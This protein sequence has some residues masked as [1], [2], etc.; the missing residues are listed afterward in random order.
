MRSR[1]VQ[2]QQQR[3]YRPREI[4]VRAFL[5]FRGAVVGV[6][7]ANEC[8]DFT[9]SNSLCKFRDGINTQFEHVISVINNSVIIGVYCSDAAILNLST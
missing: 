6:A 8:T 1:G 3:N 7:K 4:S 2:R 9:H 5:F